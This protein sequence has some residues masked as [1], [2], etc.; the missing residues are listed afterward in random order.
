[1]PTLLLFFLFIAIALIIF[2]VKTIVLAKEG[3]RVVV[4]RLGKL[5]RVH[6]PGMV[7]I[8]PFIDRVVKV[9][10]DSIAGWRSFSEKELEEKVVQ[11]AMGGDR[12]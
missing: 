7:I 1:V 12:M 2:A 11:R 4:F 8:V 9:R 10:L 3:E 5:M 6:G